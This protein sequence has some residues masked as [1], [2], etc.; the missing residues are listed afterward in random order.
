[1][2]RG[3]GATA[4]G[5]RHRYASLGS[6]AQ[7]DVH[8]CAVPSL[9][10]GP[11]RS[12]VQA[13]HGVGTSAES[14]A[15]TGRELDNGTARSGRVP[16]TYLDP[17]V[18]VRVGHRARCPAVNGLTAAVRKQLL[19]KHWDAERCD[20]SGGRDP[21]IHDRLSQADVAGRIRCATREQRC[22]EK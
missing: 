11:G 7:Y 21:A 3:G 8:A 1:M 16:D 19:A 2:I 6:D 12:K 4:S 20:P 22:S 13:R 9:R 18:A 17:V 5:T 15:S 14:R 10:T